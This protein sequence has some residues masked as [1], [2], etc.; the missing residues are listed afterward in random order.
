M[1]LNSK[2]NC[3]NN[4]VL[5]LLLKDNVRA[6]TQSVDSSFT[7]SRTQYKKQVVIWHRS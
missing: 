5:S 2:N 4:D 6:L 7:F 1:K 3:E